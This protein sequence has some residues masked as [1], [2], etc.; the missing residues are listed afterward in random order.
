MSQV[1]RR[2]HDRESEVERWRILGDDY[3]YMG[4][5]LTGLV[6]EKSSIACM[7]VLAMKR[8]RSSTM[9]VVKHLCRKILY[10]GDFLDADLGSATEPHLTCIQ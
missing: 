2:R 10:I 4:M 1:P 3:I 5:A 8:C 6:V 7:T 9:N